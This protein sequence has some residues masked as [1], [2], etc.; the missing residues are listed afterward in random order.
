VELL[1]AVKRTATLAPTTT[2]LIRIK[3]TGNQITISAQDIDYARGGAE[4]LTCQYEGE[5]MEIGFK[6]SYLIALL[7][8]LGMSDLRIELSA[9][10]F[11]GLF[12]PL[13]E[14]AEKEDTLMLLMP[15]SIDSGY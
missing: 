12:L 14:D 3:L 7:E 5:E 13:G 10:Q 11:A 1:Q 15:M 2:E 8:N 6:A 4:R 9:P